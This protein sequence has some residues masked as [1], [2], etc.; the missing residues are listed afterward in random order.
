MPIGQSDGDSSS[1]AV[2]SFLVTLFCV[3]LTNTNCH[4]VQQ[5][6]WS[7]KSWWNYS[8]D[9]RNIRT[10]AYFLSPYISLDVFTYCRT[11][12]FQNLL[13]SWLWRRR[14]ECDLRTKSRCMSRDL[15]KDDS[16]PVLHLLVGSTGLQR[17]GVRGRFF[18]HR[19]G[20]YFIVLSAGL[21]L[22]CS[23]CLGVNVP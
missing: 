14:A 17:G 10:M 8:Q 3:K 9:T 21:I 6:L 7:S 11:L 5:I 2:P 16:L 15:Y 13:W 23:F 18:D 19:Q 1:V 20:N 4:G 22:F 12:P